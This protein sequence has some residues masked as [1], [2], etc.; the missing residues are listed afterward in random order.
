MPSRSMS[1]SDWGLICVLSA[2][3]G[4]AFFFNTIAVAEVP[5]MTAALGRVCGG[6]L[7]LL[8]IAR[9]MGAAMLPRHTWGPLA[10]MGLLNSVL[11]FSL[12]MWSQQY[13][14]SGL[15]SI[16]IATTPLFSVVVAH[17][18]TDDD[19][20]T[21]GRA[22]GLLAGIIGVA[23]MIGPEV[24]HDLG[25]SVLAQLAVLLGAFLYAASG[26]YGR[27][28]R[29]YPPA[30][31]AAGQMVFATILLAPAAAFVERAWRLPA[32]SPA[33]LAAIAGLAILSTALGYIIYF[34]VL[35]RAGATNLLLV[36]FLV[37]VS[38]ILLGVGILGERLT[39]RQI[40]GML[41]I[42]IGL[43]A[44]DGRLARWLVSLR[45]SPART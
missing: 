9:V 35:A 14:A 30:A 18:T 39:P 36:N 16:L 43:A 21:P 27:R 24:L 2:F 15:A 31:V 32:P 34:R 45:S 33:A 19:K 44:I 29:A 11:P 5:P 7:L 12:V 4:G 25:T 26:V 13:V 42:G 28:F 6:A 23:V 20:L 17:M 40:A 38:A 10:L 1:A 41:I 22:V 8:L 37:P 3:W